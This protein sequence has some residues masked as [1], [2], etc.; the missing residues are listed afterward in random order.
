M[1]DSTLKQI[2]AYPNY[3]VTIDG[4][5]FNNNRGNKMNWVDN[6]K[7]YKSVK[8]Y[9]SSRPQG[10]LC[11]VHRLVMSTFSPTEVSTL[12]VNHIDGDKA[13]NTLS[14]LEWVTKSENT[15]H[16]HST[17]L[18]GSRDK[19]TKAQVI[20][21]KQKLSQ[22]KREST[23]VLAEHYGVNTSIIRKIALGYLYNYV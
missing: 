22:I 1:P 9:N 3:S 18:F 8:L 17:G 19:L 4:D 2:V 5:V 16:A 6:G 11:L 7:G 10:R 20:E 21:L 23:K 13:N 15:R 12:D 14:N